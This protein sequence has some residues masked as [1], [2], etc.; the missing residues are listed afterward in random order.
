[1]S[2]KN[3]HEWFSIK[4]INPICFMKMLRLISAHWC[5][6]KI[7][8]LDWLVLGLIHLNIYI[9]S[10]NLCFVVFF[11]KK[12][13]RLQILEH[14]HL[15]GKLSKYD[16]TNF[17]KLLLLC[18]SITF[19]LQDDLTIE[20]YNLYKIYVIIICNTEKIQ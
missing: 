18:P 12:Y 11:W 20:F 13:F 8:F 7:L 4:T 2:S 16:K 9:L 19:C 10:F 14:I 17:V 3:I 6:P 1:M 5:F 15:M